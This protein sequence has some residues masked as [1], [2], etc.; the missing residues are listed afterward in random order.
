MFS[1]IV[2]APL[3]RLPSCNTR[4]P[5]WQASRS[6]CLLR[7][8]ASSSMLTRRRFQRMDSF[9]NP[10]HHKSTRRSQG[11]QSLPK[12]FPAVIV[13]Q[14]LRP[15]VSATSPAAKQR[16][17][18]AR[19]LP[20]CSMVC[21]DHLS[22]MHCAMCAKVTRQD[23]PFRELVREEYLCNENAEVFCWRAWRY[24]IDMPELL[25]SRKER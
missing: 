15:R 13:M 7:K 12:P 6:W 21:S 10:Y 4:D 14:L 1:I 17:L 23:F 22:G 18:Q 11:Q 3:A 8:L 25:S 20:C 5:E 16:A 2:Y 19:N 9:R 24:E